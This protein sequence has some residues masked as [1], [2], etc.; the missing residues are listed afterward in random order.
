MANT[1][2]HVALAIG[3]TEEG[4]LVVDKCDLALDAVPIPFLS[5]TFSRA[6]S[7]GESLPMVTGLQWARKRW[8]VA[9]PCLPSERVW[10][11]LW[12]TSILLEGRHGQRARRTKADCHPRS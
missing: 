9:P 3:R 2:Y 10:G 6:A 11:V 12:L 5:E 1:T 8:C 7:S 4:D